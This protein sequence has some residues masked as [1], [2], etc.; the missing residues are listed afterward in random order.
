MTKA[1]RDPGPEWAARA[2]EMQRRRVAEAAA[3]P[4]RASEIE[5]G[6]TPVARARGPLDRVLD[7]IRRAIGR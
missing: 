3:K 5:P 6:R 1:V 2:A 7:R 4:H